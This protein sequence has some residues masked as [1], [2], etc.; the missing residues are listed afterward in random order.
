MSEELHKRNMYNSPE[1]INEYVYY[2]IGET[3]INQLKKGGIIPGTSYTGIERKKVDGLILRKEKPFAVIEWKLDSELSSIAKIEDAINQEIRVA[4]KLGCKL[5][6]LT[7]EKK[8]FWINIKTLKKISYKGIDITPSFVFNLDTILLFDKA[9]FQLNEQNNNLTDETIEYM[10]PITLSR[11]VWQDI[12]T[13]NGATPENALYSFVEFFIFKYLSDLGILKGSFD[14]NYLNNMYEIDSE[15]E[16]L[17]YY[18][19][20]IRPK[21]KDLFKPNPE[22]GTTIINGTIFVSKDKKAVKGYSHVFKNILKRFD[23]FGELKYI[24]YDFKS[25]LFESFLKESISKKNW[26]QYFTPLT[27]VDEMTSMADSEIKEGVAICDPACGV[28]KFLLSSVYNKDFFK[29]NNNGEIKREVVLKGFDKGF[30]HDEQKTI[31]LAKA[32]MLIYFSDFLRENSD[33]K[34]IRKFSELLNDTFLLKTNSILGTLSEPEKETYD[35]ILSNPPY[36]TSGTT[37]L[38]SEIQRDIDLRSYYGNYG[39][40]IESL[41]IEWIVNALKKD[42]K[43]YIVI[44]DSMLYRINDGT[45]RKFLIN[46]VVIEAIISLPKK[47]FFSTSKKTSI[48]I[49]KKKK[50]NTE[51]QKTPVMLFIVN[52]IGETLD[53]DRFLILENDL[54]EATTYYKMFKDDPINSSKLLKNNSE[55]LIF[56]DFDNLNIDNLTA[57]YYFSKDLLIKFERIEEVIVRTNEEYADETIESAQIIS[58]LSKEIKGIESE[59]EEME[60]TTKPYKLDD[61]FDLSHTSNSS[62]FTKK[63][64]NQNKGNIPVYGAS[65]NRDIPSY[66]YV[67]DNIP[68]VKYFN[69]CLTYTI[70]GSTGLVFY[71]EGR[72]SLSEKVLPLILKDEFKEFILPQ[73]LEKILPI[74]FIKENFSRE[75]KAGKTRIKE[76]SIDLPTDPDTM[77]PSLEIQ[78]VINDKIEQIKQLKIQIADEASKMID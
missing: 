72:F 29:L 44:P 36:V 68:A 64:I 2:N 4:E 75:V 35:L 17:E 67:K 14:F 3:T 58:E 31:I 18:V 11:Q 12:W 43:A 49:F 51:K 1:I 13:V 76:I 78:R 56:V 61:I 16:V 19:T 62:K 38:R 42:G 73:Y 55:R 33:E 15:E 21:M 60:F 10:N 5:L 77:T 27:I 66:G 40:G 74:E 69:D 9:N 26:G 63:F 45:L 20:R 22:D 7:S 46:K 25:K 54:K 39:I 50:D 52:N 8:S 41:F 34:S 32:N 30:D 57:E 65:Q 71:R 70:D 53:K 23:K 59:I 37:N 48:V 47:S 28:G 24:D 6:I